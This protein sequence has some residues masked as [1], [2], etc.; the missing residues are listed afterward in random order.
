MSEG[1]SD[2]YIKI[3]QILGF[4]R[5]RIHLYLE[6]LYP[7]VM[8]NALLDEVTE[9]LLDHDRELLATTHYPI[10]TL[11]ASFRDVVEEQGS[12]PDSRDHQD[13]VFSRAHFSMALGVA[14]AA[15][16]SDGT[17]RPEKA[18]LIDPTNY[19]RHKDWKRAAACSSN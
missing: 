7:T 16:G 4:F 15:W 17:P 9:R 18:W 6:N 2:E 12:L 14:V 10:V 1:I 8:P 11:A 19:V 13:V 5:E 3:D